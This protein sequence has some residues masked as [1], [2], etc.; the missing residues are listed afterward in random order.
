MAR[1]ATEVS[2]VAIRIVIIK[3]II[4]LVGVCVEMPTGVLLYSEILMFSRNFDRA[5]NDLVQ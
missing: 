3:V 1:S 4:Q 2:Q 5:I